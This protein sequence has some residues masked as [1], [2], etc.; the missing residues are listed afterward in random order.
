ME[1]KGHKYFLSIFTRLM[2]SSYPECLIE[3]NPDHEDHYVY[4]NNIFRL[5]S[6]NM[7]IEVYRTSFYFKLDPTIIRRVKEFSYNGTWYVQPLRFNIQLT[8]RTGKTYSYPELR[9]YLNDTDEDN[10]MTAT[11]IFACV[12][13][14]INFFESGLQ[15]FNAQKI[16]NMVGK[17]VITTR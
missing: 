2:Q 15:E 8:A 16:K 17:H 4:K 7:A 13:F 12:N 10:L 3:P 1:E 14:T 5:E 6:K 11:Y 9:N